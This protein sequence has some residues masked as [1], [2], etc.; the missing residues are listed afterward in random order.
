MASD[1]PTPSARQRTITAASIH[2]SYR[3]PF[4]G[5]LAFRRPPVRRQATTACLA[6]RLP[7]SAEETVARPL[8]PEV[9]AQGGPLVFAPE[10]PAPL[11]LRDHLADEVL[12][13]LRQVGEQDVEAVAGLAL[14]P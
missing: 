14:K 12:Q 13:A 8:Q 5:G 2:R 1:M 7:S 6:R 9:L 4:M 3:S 11:Q 10:N